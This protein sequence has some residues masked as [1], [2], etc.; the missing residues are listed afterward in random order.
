[1]CEV[2]RAKFG[3]Q[4]CARSF[5]REVLVRKV[6]GRKVLVREVCREFLREVSAKFCKREIAF[7]KFHRNFNANLLDFSSDLCAK[8]RSRFHHAACRSFL[9][10]KEILLTSEDQ[11]LSPSCCQV[12]HH[13]ALWS[14]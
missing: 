14:R 2:W 3:A 6:L 9:E 12:F 7:C 8:F 13:S 1:M 4:F 5:V 11:G 10:S